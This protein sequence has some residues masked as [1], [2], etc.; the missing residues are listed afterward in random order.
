MDK[1][2][3]F[4][5]AEVRSGQGCGRL[6]SPAPVQVH[7]RQSESARAAASGR[8][9]GGVVCTRLARVLILSSTTPYSELYFN[10]RIDALRVDSFK[11]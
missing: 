7:L 11:N 4:L 8:G 9:A 2:T 3:E 1:L 5:A 6:S 10:K